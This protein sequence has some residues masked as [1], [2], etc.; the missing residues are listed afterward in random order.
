MLPRVSNQTESTE[1]PNVEKE[2]EVCP[3][4]SMKASAKKSSSNEIT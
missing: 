3:M 4:K 1:S 2:T